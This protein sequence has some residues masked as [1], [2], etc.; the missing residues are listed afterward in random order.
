MVLNSNHHCLAVLPTTNRNHR[1]LE[2]VG[3][4]NNSK[5]LPPKVYSQASHLLDNSLSSSNSVVSLVD[6]LDQLHNLNNKG[7]QSTLFYL[8]SSNSRTRVNLLNLNPSL[9]NN[10]NSNN[11]PKACLVLL[12]YH[13]SNHHHSS[14]DNNNNN[15]RML[16]VALAHNSR[17]HYLAMLRQHNRSHR[18]HSLLFKTRINQDNLQVTLQKDLTHLEFSKRIHL[19]ALNRWI[20]RL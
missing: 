5:F 19:M 17:L 12:H 10:H 18:H 1:C 2:Q 11:Q 20:M 14:Q 6:S 4:H 9:D 3:S 13:N 16:E 15:H 7:H 8:D